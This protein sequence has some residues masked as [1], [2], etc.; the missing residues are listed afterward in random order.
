MMNTLPRS[1]ALL[2]LEPE[3][4]AFLIESKTVTKKVQK[5]YESAQLL[6]EKETEHEVELFG[7][8]R[9]S[10]PKNQILD[11]KTKNQK[12]KNQE[13]KNRR[14]LSR[15]KAKPRAHCLIFNCKCVVKY[16]VSNSSIFIYGTDMICL[17]PRT[18]AETFASSL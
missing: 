6:I 9:V 12:I 5:I 10:V 17:F 11:R 15:R 13:R 14:F 4:I 16:H 2:G 8:F 7:G 1:A 18:M 3:E